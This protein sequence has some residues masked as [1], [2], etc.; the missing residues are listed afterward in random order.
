MLYRSTKELTEWFMKNFDSLFGFDSQGI[1]DIC[2]FR[3]NN[4]LFGSVSHEEIAQ[5]FLSNEKEI[6]KYENCAKWEKMPS[7]KDRDYIPNFETYLRR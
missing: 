1:E 2:F 6:L 4:I 3:N 7:H 5:L